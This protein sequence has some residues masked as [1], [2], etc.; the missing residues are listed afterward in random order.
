[1]IQKRQNQST[2]INKKSELVYNL[3]TVQRGEPIDA[4]IYT[5]FLEP[6]NSMD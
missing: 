6:V 1:M 3:G 4:G 2:I 5:T